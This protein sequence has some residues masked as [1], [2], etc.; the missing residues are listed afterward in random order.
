MEYILKKYLAESGIVP[1]STSFLNGVKSN[2]ISA[3]VNATGLLPVSLV[4][5]SFLISK[6]S[7]PPKFCEEDVSAIQDYLPEP[8]RLHVNDLQFSVQC[9]LVLI[10]QN[11]R[12]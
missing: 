10:S 6:I 8:H 5:N 11:L 1:L 4:S 12:L 7:S 9:Y 3:L 2:C